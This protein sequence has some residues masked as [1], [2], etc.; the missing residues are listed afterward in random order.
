MPRTISVRAGR[1]DD[2]SPAARAHERKIADAKQNSEP[3]IGLL[4]DDVAD[5]RHVERPT[6]EFV[7]AS[8]RSFR[9]ELNRKTTDTYKS[10]HSDRDDFGHGDTVEFWDTSVDKQTF[11]HGHRT[12][13]SYY[14]STLEESRARHQ[15]IRL[16]GGI[17]AWDIDADSLERVHEWIDRTQE[18]GWYE[19]EL[20]AVEIARARRLIRNGLPENFRVELDGD[21]GD[22]F[23][24]RVSLPDG[25]RS[26]T[27]SS[28]S[29]SAAEQA[30]AALVEPED[31]VILLRRE[32]RSRGELVVVVKSPN[33]DGV[34]EG[35]VRICVDHEYGSQVETTIPVGTSDQS[36]KRAEEIVRQATADDR[37]RRRADYEAKQE[38]RRLRREAK[39]QRQTDALACQA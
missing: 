31:I 2:G 34:P 32:R 18:P 23:D 5:L 10:R 7:A 27:V 3:T 38:A 13:G 21:H 24:F 22:A 28:A 4:S 29:E 11:P 8:G 9:V 16:H 14:I 20:H 33:Q 15:G 36:L 19:R 37:A 25:S 35:M 1:H 39:K 17:P 12:S 30:R 6:F 26:I